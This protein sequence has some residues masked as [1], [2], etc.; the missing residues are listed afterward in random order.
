M[1]LDAGADDFF[2]ALNSGDADEFVDFGLPAPDAGVAPS[3]TASSSSSS[4]GVKEEQVQYHKWRVRRARWLGVLTYMYYDVIPLC[5]NDGIQTS[6]KRKKS[7]AAK[8]SSIH[9][10]KEPASSSSSSSAHPQPKTRP[11]DEPVL[12][13]EDRIV[14]LLV[15]ELKVN[16]VMLL[17]KKM[18]QAGKSD[19]DEFSELDAEQKSGSLSF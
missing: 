13:M 19:A 5:V 11:V 17:I 14:N 4:S 12:P 1:D 10:K 9:V 2:A 7:D 6:E 8:K 15:P 3:T 18:K 16:D